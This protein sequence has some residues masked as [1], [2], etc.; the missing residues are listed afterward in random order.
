MHQNF[1]G[2]Y[3]SG[4]LWLGGVK[5]VI[6]INDVHKLL[7]RNK[8]WSYLQRCQCVILLL[9]R[10][11]KHLSSIFIFGCC[12]HFT[13]R[14]YEVIFFF[15]CLL[16]RSAIL[17]AFTRSQVFVISKT[18]CAFLP[19]FSRCGCTI[20]CL[21][22]LMLNQWTSAFSSSTS[23]FSSVPLQTSCLPLPTVSLIVSLAQ[24]ESLLLSHF[25]RSNPIRQHGCMMSV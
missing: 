14:K 2:N 21:Y 1:Y 8:F 18:F 3:D 10:M 9:E 4:L 7:V 16:G 12:A 19:I 24:L 5:K 6:I 11:I 25:Q 17:K 20:T 13:L 23:R 15:V 22:A